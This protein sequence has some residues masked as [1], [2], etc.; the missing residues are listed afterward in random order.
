[1]KVKTQKG[2]IEEYDSQKIVD[3]LTADVAFAKTQGVLTDLDGA[4][5]RRIA[6][7]V[8]TKISKMGYADDEIISSDIIR[9]LTVSELMADGEDRVAG[10]VNLVG[11]Q[12][13]RIAEIIEGAADHDNANLQHN[14]ET[15]HKIIADEV[16][17]KYYLGQLPSDLA[18]A[19]LSG[20]LHI[21]DLE[22]FGTRLFCQDWDLRYFFYYGLMPD[23]V[24]TTASVS[25]PAKNPEVAILH[26]VKALSAAQTN[27]SGGQGFYNFLTFLAPYL[28]GLSYTEIYQL[29]QMFV[30]EMTQ[31]MVA[32]G[33]Q[34]V[35]SSV[36]LT[37]GVP[38]LWRDKP[39]VFKG[40]VSNRLYG[41]FEREVRLAFKALMNVMLEGDYWGK[42]FN[43][44][45]PEIAI[46]P[47]FIDPATW[48]EK[49]V[50]GFIPAGI[51]ERGWAV[52]CESSGETL[53]SYK[54]LYK[55][56][57]KLT[58]KYG[59]PYFD[60]MLPAYRGHSKGG[61]SCYQS[62]PG[63]TL[64]ATK[65]VDGIKLKHIEDIS[66]NDVL[67]TPTGFETFESMLKYETDRD[68]LQLKLL[69]GRL[70]RCTPEHEMP[71]VR[72]GESV[73]LKA[74]DIQKGDMLKIST[75]L[76]N[77][78]GLPRHPKSTLGDNHDIKLAYFMGLY[79]AEGNILIRDS[80]TG[81]HRVQISFGEENLARRTEEM[82]RDLFGWNV[83]T[84]H[85][86][87]NEYRVL[88]YGRD[89]CE[90]LRDVL[91]LAEKTGKEGKIPDHIFV[92]RDELKWAFIQGY[93]QG[94]GSLGTTENGYG[95]K[96]WRYSI[97]TVSRELA[98]GFL[99]LTASLG[100]NFSLIDIKT[101][102][103]IQL[104]L[105]READLRKFL[106]CQ[107]GDFD[108]LLPVR[109]ITTEKYTGYVYDPI[110]VENHDFVLGTGL[111]SGNCCSYNFSIN[112]SQDAEF[113][114]K[115]IFKDGKHFSMGS[116]QVVTLNVPRAAYKTVSYFDGEYY[117]GKDTS[118]LRIQGFIDTLKS[119]MISACDVFKFKK[120]LLEPLIAKGRV[121]FATQRPKDP[122]TGAKG[123]PAADLSSMVWTIGV[124]GM[125]EAVHVLCGKQLHES[126]EA[127]KLAERVMSELKLYCYELSDQFGFKIAL[128]RTPAE[129]V[130]QRFAVLDL[131]DS[132]YQEQSF[133]VLKG[134]KMKA[135][136]L[137]TQG[138]RD[139]PIYY[140]N[141]CMLPAE[142]DNI[143]QRLRAESKFFPLVDG[144]NIF[145]VW[146][147]ESFSDPRGLMDFAM[148]V[149]RNTDIGYF[150]FTKDLTVCKDC[151][152]AEGG[153]HD[154]CGFCR[155]TNV[156]YV[157]RI[158]GYMSSVSGWNAAK[159][160]ELE[161]RKRIQV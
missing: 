74:C 105:G 91:H 96:Y 71:V 67:L 102:P 129:T 52:T 157:S 159:R 6:R 31:M 22:Y 156:D 85:I 154:S 46:E 130:A 108:G 153:L 93:M 26:A 148:N 33:G 145:H 114:D 21:H 113:A 36:Q 24:G 87:G 5:V 56:A 18:N 144:G 38:E 68:L 29:M 90:Y 135:L 132:R 27:F 73:R 109:Y 60:N 54:E 10:V 55:L 20:D 89:L 134:D 63:D 94:D 64:V 158:T 125:N 160:Q 123:T 131:L 92:A 39:A 23:G 8:N 124:V 43:F 152:K 104:V 57:F 98:E 106:S 116:S 65:S 34:V 7:R 101:R 161:D 100:H 128:A 59:T 72:N 82:I 137:A 42:P 86:G 50:I 16:S 70:I 77:T 84:H 110:N 97:E 14:P 44:P 136:E 62:I 66:D 78:G 81:G 139:L 143:H 30:Y 88:A 80:K 115:M 142:C 111:I 112:P 118:D 17:K 12:P 28:E 120:S 32:R 126:D 48:E 2:F 69:N 117:A 1:M 61:I 103:N 58:A 19:H 4:H 150:A 155:S 25:G 99:L 122:I 141:G 51:D 146:L 151:G 35:F 133:K 53:P 121:P 95:K 47:E 75:S 11:L 140:T 9:G 149:A 41:E 13:K 147:G 45:K 127:V 107:Q 49:P 138:Q 119:G 3:S 15:T 37:P 83:K 79:T 40:Q 76:P